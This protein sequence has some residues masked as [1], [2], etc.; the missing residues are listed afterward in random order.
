M[1]C[2]YLKSK[3]EKDRQKWLVALGSAKA[4]AATTAASSAGESA[5]AAD[6]SSSRAASASPT[7]DCSSLDASLRSKKTELKLYC[8]LL[9]QQ[10]HS[11]KANCMES[12]TSPEAMERLNEGASLLAKT[13]DTFICSLDDV[14]KLALA[15][16]EGEGTK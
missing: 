15:A 1:Q 4:A 8:D 9:M 2:I 14:M 10:T 7:A 11:L 12:R 6:S 3:D 13:C 5:G 16:G